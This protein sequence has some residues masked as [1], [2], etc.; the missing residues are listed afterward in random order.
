[1]PRRTTK[2]STA[3]GGLPARWQQLMQLLPGYDPLRD[4]A[5][6][7]FD[8]VLAQDKIDFFHLCLRHVKGVRG[9]PP[10]VLEDWLQAIVG[11][12][13]GWVD[14]EGYRR[15]RECL[16]FVP[17][18]NAK[19]MLAAGIVLC[20]LVTDGEPG[21]EI[22]GAGK[23]ED[24]AGRVYEYASL[25]VKAD[26][27]LQRHL[28]DFS[29]S[30]T[31]TYEQQGSFYRAISGEPAGKH[32]F[33]AHLI[34]LDELHEQPD[35][36]LLDALITSMSARKQPLIVYCTTSDFERPSICNE[37]Y[38]YACGVRDG[39][40]QDPQFLPVIYEVSTE[41]LKK[42]PEA[43]KKEAYWYKAN[44][45]LGKS[46][47]LAYMHRECLRAQ[48]EPSYLNTFLRL[49]LNIR[50]QQDI[51]W[52]DTAAWNAC[53]GVFNEAELLGQPCWGGLD[54]G[55]GRDLS[56]LALYFPESQSVLSY[57]WVPALRAKE[58]SV[59]GKREYE[60]WARQG[61]LRLTEGNVTDY[62]V[63]R[64]DLR[65]LR[66]QYNI[67]AIAFDRWNSQNL[68]NQFQADGFQMIRFGQGM[69]SMAPAMKALEG[70]YLGGQLR[71]GDNPVLSWAAGNVQA[72]ED[73][74]G[75]MKPDKAKS[76]EKIDPFVALVMAVGVHELQPELDSPSIYATEELLVL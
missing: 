6:Y 67:R 1:M 61:H 24:Q 32:G 4:A 50:T 11:N 53:G 73:A 51:R 14:D 70:L 25:M 17:R 2:P 68:E 65:E 66:E 47:S 38:A 33:N 9:R 58:L 48:N 18:K 28:K 57:S 64:R 22:Y 15:Y 52:L 63:I 34:V 5:G 43:W 8:P 49:E 46:K 31:I 44:P 41:D 37:K 59:K 56:S 55:G 39:T 12:L 20:T 29:S 71:H 76:P 13:Y 10:F 36:R 54:L 19:S 23:D 27:D 69:Q 26:A 62:E 74:A 16:L 3:P 72:T 30:K 40:I 7:H 60:V 35:R 45:N 75:N 42:D 21:A